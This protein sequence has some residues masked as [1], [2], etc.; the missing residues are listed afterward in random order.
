M[1]CGN[2]LL[3]VQIVILVIIVYGN[4]TLHAQNNDIPDHP[5]LFLLEKEEEG[6]KKML[7][8]EE[9]SKIH[10]S[11]L[12][13]AKEALTLPV[14]VRNST[15]LLDLARESLRRIFY[16]SYAYRMT[17]IYDYAKRAEDEMIT[18]S[19]FEDWCPQK[20]LD[21]SEMTLAVAIGYDWL[22]HA[23][24]EDT[25]TLLKVAIREKGLNQSLESEYNGW[26]NGGMNW[27][28]V[29]SAGMAIGALAIYE[30]DPSF[31]QSIIERSAKSL[32]YIM[33][34][35]DPSGVSREGYTYWNYGT[36][37]N[38]LFL[39]ATEKALGTD[40]DLWRNHKGY[41]NSDE[42]IYQLTTPRLYAFNY[43]DASST[44]GLM[45]SMFWY[46]HK[47]QDPSILWI[48]KK[49][50][51]REKTFTDRLLPM[52]MV[53]GIGLSFKDLK[54]P[55]NN[56]YVGESKNSIVTMRTSHKENGCF[57]GFKLGTPNVSHSHMDIGSFIFEAKG[58]RW[59]LDLGKD[60]YEKAEEAGINLSP[61]DQNS[62]RWKVFRNNNYSHNTLTV[63]DS[64]QRAKGVSYI[65]S[66]SD[67]P[68]FMN[69]IADV[70]PNYSNLLQKALRGVALVNNGFAIIQDEIKTKG[71]W[72]KIRWNMLTRA[73]VSIKKKNEIEL[74]LQ[75][76]IVTLKIEK[77]QYTFIK[78]EPAKGK[79]PFDSTN[80]NTTMIG[81]ET[82]V[83]PNTEVTIQIKL[84]PSC[85]SNSNINVPSLSKWPKCIIN[86]K[87]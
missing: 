19:K 39:S 77:P 65:Q 20:F 62:G 1:N 21:T 23:L 29:C 16:L 40:F 45:V 17:G 49:I 46:A 34:L 86:N 57:L 66:Y 55:Y 6:I 60:D 18:V 67:T 84:I 75:G 5:R 51:D 61:K 47:K 12:S 15:R 56:F 9:W 73:D 30:E 69:A 43:S 63:N 35:F 27:N 42:Y 36:S 25:R 82:T 3:H 50:L 33:K 7:N 68:L 83:A 87:Y 71:S 54:Y 81:I 80:K 59:A 8:E 26:L 72:T 10:S 28:Q 41:Q 52:A 48:S 85:S 58:I 14:P 53:W 44:V 31:C 13:Y 24:K 78:L 4:I 76:E 11:I 37:F 32:P 38:N 70:T 74:Y 2:R 79:Y 22:Y 64:L